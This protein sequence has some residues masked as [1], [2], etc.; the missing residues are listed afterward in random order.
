[1]LVLTASRLASISCR[2]LIVAL[3]WL[4]LVTPVRAADADE[5]G[6]VPSY[7]AF[8]YGIEDGLPHNGA[9]V[10]F[11]SRTGYIWIGSSGLC[12]FDGVRFVTYREFNT[13]ELAS[14]IIRALYED[15]SGTLWICT[16]NGL[17]SY[18]D[19]KFEF[20]GLKGIEIRSV[21][22]S[23]KGT[24][25]IATSQGLWEYRDRKF[26]SHA[27]DPGI[28]Q[29]DLMLVFRDSKGR[30]WI[31]FRNR[32]VALF[33]NGVARPLPSTA[34]QY[35]TIY[36]ITELA[37][38]T[39]LLGTDRGIFEVADSGIREYA[40]TRTLRNKVIRGLFSDRQGNLW[41][42]N[43]TDCFLKEKGKNT[44]VKIP[45]PSDALCRDII[46]DRE[47]TLW[48]GTAGD[49]I[50]RLRPSAF[51]MLAPEHLPLG[52]N[53]PSVT[54][55]AQGY[56]W[57]SLNIAGVA[58]IAPD[59]TVSYLKKGTETLL[60]AW[61]ACLAKDGS[62]WFASLDALRVWRD[63]MTT[64][65]PE[66]GRVRA[67]YQDKAGTI[68]IGS[69]T[70]GVTQYKDGQFT[71]TPNLRKMRPNEKRGAV[72][73][74]KIFY[75]DE[76]GAM[77][78]G[79]ER[80]GIVKIKDGITTYYDT[81]DG[82]PNNDIRAIYHDADDNL[83]V[84]TKGSGLI[85][86]SK[87][88]W[89]TNEDLSAPF[90][91]QVSA[92]VEDN[93]HRLWLGTPQGIL[94][95]PKKELLEIARG[96]KKNTLFR[97]AGK[98]DGVRP[99]LIGI[100]G[101]PV[102]WQAPDGK[103]WFATK[104]GLVS[105]NPARILFNN[106]V[107]PVQ[108]ENVK[109]DGERARSTHSIRLSAGGHSLSIDYTALSFIQS[110]RVLFRYKMEGHDKDW[111]DADTRRTA[112]YM[113]LD[114]GDYRFRVIACNNDGVWNETGATLQIFQAPFFYQTWWFYIGTSLGII[115]GTVTLFRWRT[116]KLRWE[117]TLLENRVAERTKELVQAKEQAEA[118]TKAKSM[119]LANM[120]HE[121]RTPMNG[122]IG[123]TGLLID[124]RLDEEQREYAETVRNSGEALLTIINDILDFSKIEAGK[125]ELE[126]S[127]FKLRAAVE[128]AVELL[129][130]A[131]SRKHLEL[132]YWIE[133][134]MPNEVIGD[135]GRFRQILIN[136][137]GNAVKFTEK[138]EV[139]VQL[140]QLS[141]SDTQVSLR[142]EVRDT[143]IGMTPEACARLFQSFT[144]VDNSATR[145]FG[146]TGL[147]LAISRQLVELMGGHI[148][149]ESVPGKGS[150]FWFNLNLERGAQTSSQSNSPAA[151]VHGKHVLIVDDN[152]TNRR[153][154]VHLLR[155]WKLFP[156]EA[157]RG[158]QALDMLIMASHQNQPFDLAILDFQ[159]PGFDGLQLA[160]AIRNHPSLHDIHLM[161]LSSSLSKEQRAELEKNNFSAI[162]P[163]P[164]RQATLVRALE[165]LWGQ[166]PAAPAPAATQLPLSSDASR[167]TSTRILI[168]ED[169][170]T[171]QILAKRMVEKMG[172]K[173]D[174]VANG[175]EAIEAMSRINYRLVLMDCQM[176][177]MDGYEA[178]KE[179]R[180]DEN[181]A[182]RI[183]IIALTANASED[184][185]SHCLS[186]G[187]D[188]YLSKP[189]RFAEL[190]TMIKL[191]LKQP[192][193]EK[194]A[195]DK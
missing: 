137:I 115:A 107:P 100:G 92:I 74:A 47:G 11:Q 91:D 186:V 111:V 106:T 48:I 135:P 30:I 29:P 54:G 14:N 108:I 79:L 105:V 43:D 7:C 23:E 36:R 112:F 119:F 134:D 4:P 188:D 17:T 143:G 136:L 146:G 166:A 122:V 152:E 26:I 57:A 82:I 78:I 67:I 56:V 77:Y 96:E 66:Y 20:V 145:R 157:T 154:L 117:K 37:D 187:M 9:P 98:E 2:A 89:W 21:V 50:M 164:V 73:C 129:S 19:G 183:P 32:G 147:G 90:S 15:E 176:P 41:I 16:Q 31:G 8:A 42:V 192:T 110:N 167:L 83:W 24:L 6:E 103:I 49:G 138:G 72:I 64:E 52:G 178:T 87:G 165:K 81:E 121:I 69:E 171:N 151:G 39:I 189:V 40:E 51:Q 27:Q 153:L 193:Q 5:T 46:Q 65:Y 162:F 88:R 179:I 140:S 44:L 35:S 95:W 128:D 113:N 70:K 149:V 130:S 58:R 195:S 133:H 173:G 33:E 114:P 185:R 85:V 71:S 132:A 126:K 159:M 61:S 109:V 76:E 124:T 116:H 75:E 131:A 168:A 160:Q 68:W 1:M 99:A 182:K 3:A 194:P 139:F 84:G 86:L 169:N 80:G 102:V 174:V 161:M 38:G 28:L 45:L 22:E 148:G 150:T 191:W 120:S 97:L 184:E 94:W 93:Y 125:L 12:R 181:A 104:R 141:S 13:P 180:R 172:Y 156:E 123:M 163:K 25:L 53:I 18:R 10:V 190:E 55:N 60:D 155:R 127:P 62:I 170:A 101:T 177:E 175:R 158:D 118:A 34:G 63:G 144:Q 142:I 59:G